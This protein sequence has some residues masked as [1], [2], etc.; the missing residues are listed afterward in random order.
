MKRSL[1]AF[2][3]IVAAL[4]LTACATAAGTAIGAGIGSINGNTEA[5]ALIGGGTGMLFDVF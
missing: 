4:T 2:M 1:T 3:L 5:G